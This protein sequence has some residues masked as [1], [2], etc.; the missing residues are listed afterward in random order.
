MGNHEELMLGALHELQ[1]NQYNDTYY[2][3]WMHNGGKVTM[4]SYCHL[5]ATNQT[6]ILNALENA[7]YVAEITSKQHENVLVAH[8][9]LNKKWLSEVQSGILSKDK[10]GMS[11]VTWAREEWW[12]TPNDLGCLLVTGHTSSATYGAELGEV[13]WDVKQ[14]RF[15]VDCNTIRTHKVGFVC[16][17]PTTLHYSSY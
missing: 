14:R 5:N 4:D 10:Y 12:N 15:V 16:F 8:A 2:E 3:C 7:A 6:F 1:C 13:K 17:E 9:G 11:N